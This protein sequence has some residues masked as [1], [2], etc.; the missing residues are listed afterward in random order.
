MRI[1][2]IVG[3]YIDRPGV[4]LGFGDFERLFNTCQSSVYLSDFNICQLQLA[5]YDGVVSIV[6]FFLSDLVFIKFEIL[7]QNL[8]CFF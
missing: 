4:K 2:V 5:G 8:S 1:N 6:L 7:V 3:S